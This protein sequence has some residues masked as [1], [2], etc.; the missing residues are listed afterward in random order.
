[1]RPSQRGGHRGPGGRI[2]GDPSRHRGFARPTRQR[3]YPARHRVS[4]MPRGCRTTR[5]RCQQQQGRMGRRH[6]RPGRGQEHREHETR[7]QHRPR[8]MGLDELTGNPLHHLEVGHGRSAIAV[9]V[10]PQLPPPRLHQRR[11]H[12]R[13]RHLRVTRDPR[14]KPSVL[15]SPL[16]NVLL[17]MTFEWGIALHDLHSDYERAATDAEKSA[18]TRALIRKI[19][20]QTAKD[21]LLFPALS[22]RRWRRTLKANV[23]ANLLRN[24][25]AYVVI[26]CGH[27]ADGAEKFTPAALEGETKPQWYL[28]QML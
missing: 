5:Y 1:M 25:W 19:G 17:A 10:L 21:Y 15:L 23:A 13:S 9:A 22:R 16:R 28:R 7:P 6:R 2:G 4:A 26:C 14:W 18:R 12:G 11:R 20:R 8:S 3:I 27:F 24:V